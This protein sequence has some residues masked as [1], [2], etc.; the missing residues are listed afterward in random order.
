M[1][2][3]RLGGIAGHARGRTVAI[4][5]DILLNRRDTAGL[6][7]GTQREE[8][9]ERTDIDLQCKQ[10]DNSSGRPV[11]RRCKNRFRTTQTGPS[12][13]ECR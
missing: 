11:A 3:I 7:C 6:E 8:R 2:G 12:N 4:L 10:I 5:G 1:G 13:F 9:V